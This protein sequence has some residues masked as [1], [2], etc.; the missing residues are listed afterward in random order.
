MELR[1]KYSLTPI[2][3]TVAY[4]VTVTQKTGRLCFTACNYRSIDQISTRFGTNQRYFILNIRPRGS[5]RP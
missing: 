1:L 5:D 4:R 2:I 3:H